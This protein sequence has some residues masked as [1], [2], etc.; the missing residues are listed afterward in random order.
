MIKVINK[1]GEGYTSTVLKIVILTV[2]G[3]LVLSGLVVL[4]NNAMN[5]ADKKY[6]N[7]FKA[8]QSTSTLSET[9][10]G[11]RPGG[12]YNN[13]N[14]VVSW[15]E[16]KNEYMSYLAGNPSC[17]DINFETGIIK[18]FKNNLFTPFSGK[19]CGE[20]VIDSSI[21]NIGEDSSEIFNNITTVLTN[22]NTITFQN[23]VKTI[24]GKIIDDGNKIKTINIGSGVEKLNVDISI[25]G[26]ER[27]VYSG[28]IEQFAQVEGCNN[29]PISVICSNGIYNIEG[30]K[31]K[32]ELSYTWKCDISQK[33]DGSLM[34]YCVKLDD[35]DNT[36]KVHIAGN[37]EARSSSD[38]KVIFKNKTIEETSDFPWK[39]DKISGWSSFD[40]KITSIQ[41][42]EGVDSLVEKMFADCTYLET[43]SLPNSL[44]SLPAY[45]LSN[46]SIK[47][48]TI[49]KNVSKIDEMTFTNCSSL[50]KINV[51]KKNQYFRSQ[52]GVL[53]SK[54]MRTL[55]R[56]PEG[57]RAEDSSYDGTDES[58]LYRGYTVPDGVQCLGPYSFYQCKYLRRGI[59]YP[60]TL[61]KI[62]EAAFDESG[63]MECDEYKFSVGSSTYVMLYEK[64]NNN[65][66]LI[67]VTHLE[68]TNNFTIP[69]GEFQR[70]FFDDE[71]GH[72]STFKEGPIYVAERAF[73]GTYNEALD[74]NFTNSLSSLSEI[75]IPK[76]VVYFS[77]LSVMGC[78]NLEKITYQGFARI[79]V[80][81][82]NLDAPVKVYAYKDKNDKTLIE[83]TDDVLT[84]T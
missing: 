15:D 74:E 51:V 23:S 84:E 1:R 49:P 31:T 27:I 41:I 71:E 63:V 25:N 60:E 52:D 17:D 47:K 3:A 18:K 8:P 77:K 68:G 79:W 35:D 6:A 48:I 42:H 72:P 80:S 66:F 78:N 44:E 50:E 62:C 43:L 45:L 32:Y 39:N 29:M 30:A 54:S 5:S 76:A 10:I 11:K 34:A 82:P 64:N 57:I 55:V 33:Q 21:T 67:K 28:T 9:V 75:T 22:L 7:V 16:I 61:F 56:M 83:V 46:S 4:V 81:D 58:A 40:N 13:E 65:K 73:D 14:I 69:S 53:F 2:I 37:G 12:L 19:L 20:F 26:L 38:F 59:Y 24:T 36:Y 70:D